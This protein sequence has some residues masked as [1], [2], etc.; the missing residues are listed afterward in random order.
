MGFGV[1]SLEDGKACSL[2]QSVMRNCFFSASFLISLFPFWGWLFALL[3]VVSFSLFE[4]YLLVK[5]DSAH[6]FGDV[7]A[8]TTVI[9]DDQFRED[10]KKKKVIWMNP[11]TSRFVQK[12]WEKNEKTRNC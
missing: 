4:L 10:L 11:N 9:G 5:W 6:R 7:V 3:L 2:K 8:D 1:I 12:V